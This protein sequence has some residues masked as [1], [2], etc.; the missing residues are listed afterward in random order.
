[1]AAAVHTYKARLFDKAV[2]AGMRHFPSNGRFYTEPG[3]SCQLGG[4]RTGSGASWGLA[5]SRASGESPPG[6]AWLRVPELAPQSG[7][8]E[9][10]GL[11]RG[12]SAAGTL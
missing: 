3:G 4:R 6:L 5:P 9:L 2:P 12:A 8:L 10:R 7:G 11:G 1:M